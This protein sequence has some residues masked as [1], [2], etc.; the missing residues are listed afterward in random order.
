LFLTIIL[1]YFSLYFYFLSFKYKKR[2]DTSGNGDGTILVDNDGNVTYSTGQRKEYLQNDPPHLLYYWLILEKADMLTSTFSV[3]DNY[4]GASSRH[5]ASY[6]NAP[7]PKK[8][9]SPDTV[10]QSPFQL[11]LGAAVSKLSAAV[12]NHITP[13]PTETMVQGTTTFI[14]NTSATATT[15]TELLDLYTKTK[16]LYDAAS[17]DDQIFLKVG[18]EKVKAKYLKVN[19]SL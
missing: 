1:Y 12:T 9:N 14:N 7:N 5:A 15:L 8:R 6:T 4:A 11:T 10:V 17:K 13:A 19:E 16:A 3:L 18:L 2:V